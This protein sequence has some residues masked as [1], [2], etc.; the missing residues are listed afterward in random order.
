MYVPEKK[1]VQLGGEPYHY[2]DFG[3]EA[4]PPMVFVH[5]T[6]FHS[7]L[8]EPYGRVLRDRFRVLCF[9]Q[10]W[11]GDSPKTPGSF[12][13]NRFGEDFARFLRELRLD[14]P[15]CVGH[16]M[17]ATTIALAALDSP[18][19]V[20]RAVFIDP[21]IMDPRFYKISFTVD[22]YPIASLTLKRRSVWDSREQAIESYSGKPPFDT[23]QREFVELY[24]NYG[25]AER[26]EGGFALKCRPEDEAQVYVGGTNTD[27][28]PRLGELEFPTLVIRPLESDIRRGTLAQEVVEAMPNAQLLDIPGASHYLPMENPEAVIDHILAFEKQTRN[29]ANGMGG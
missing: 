5:G 17:G 19:C 21:I 22:D 4:L 28:W 26:D 20:G 7:W 11:H 27:P 25:M 18:G 12:S 8:W 24:V 15:F 29:G 3:G 6:G 14:S 10:R 13:W 9:D 1:F 23:W 16:S 2:L